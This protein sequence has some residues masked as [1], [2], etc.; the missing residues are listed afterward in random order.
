MVPLIAQLPVSVNS[1]YWDMG[2]GEWIARMGMVECGGREERERE[3]IGTYGEWLNYWNEG[4]LGSGS[5]G[6]GDYE[7]FLVVACRRARKE[8]LL[9]VGE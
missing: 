4:K 9:Q 1:K 7:R 2:E 6:L 3:M 8:G 5:G